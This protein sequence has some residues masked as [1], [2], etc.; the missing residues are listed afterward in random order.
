MPEMP[1]W[2]HR[3]MADARI[4]AQL[5][6]R[7]AAASP[8]ILDRISEGA[9]IPAACAEHGLKRAHVRA[10]RVV[11][12]ERL[13]EWED[14]RVASA[15][16]FADEALATARN[17]KVDAAYA[18]VLVDTLKWAAAKRNPD[19]YAEIGRASCRE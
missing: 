11:D 8:D 1:S 2:Y 14:A 10:W 3:S 16:A 19:H 5:A 7:G 15:D 17:T 12:P 18:R 9:T 6:A 4:G 13:R